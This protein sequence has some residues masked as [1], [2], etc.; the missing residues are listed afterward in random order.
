V[1]GQFNRVSDGPNGPFQPW[2]NLIRLKSNGTIDPLFAPGAGLT[3]YAPGYPVMRL[4]G[5][6][7]FGVAGSGLNTVDPETAQPLLVGTCDT[8]PTFPPNAVDLGRKLDPNEGRV[9]AIV[10]QPDGRILIGGEFKCYNGIPRGGLARL[11]PNGSLDTS[12]GDPLAPLPG[13]DDYS[14]CDD[15]IPPPGVPRTNPAVAYNRAQVNAILLQP[16]GSVVVG[17]LFG[18]A[19][20]TARY[21]LARFDSAGFWI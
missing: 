4:G 7:G 15:P 11:L 16:D 5:P 19:N 18:K 9:N 10:L 2:N 20:G 12:F 8:P 1:G 3:S 6:T 13:V 21:N 17:G 14:L